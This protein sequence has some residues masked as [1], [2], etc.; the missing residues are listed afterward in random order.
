[1]IMNALTTSPSIIIMG[2]CG[3]GKSA[4]GTALAKSLNYAFVEADDFHSPSNREK[5]MNGIAL[6][7]DDRL[8]WLDSIAQAALGLRRNGN[9]PVIA[10]S[11][12]KRSYRRILSAK[13]S[14]AFFVHLTA[15]RSLLV[16]RLETRQSHFVGVPLLDSQLASLEPLEDSEEGVTLDCSQSLAV[17]T[18]Q[19]I[20]ALKPF[21]KSA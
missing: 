5:M 9:V 7:D 10:C 1:M 21:M 14:G 15:E 3:A 13:L 20:T 8:P 4:I 16:E 19:A 11:A 17:I 6:T 2:V 12:L 18:Q